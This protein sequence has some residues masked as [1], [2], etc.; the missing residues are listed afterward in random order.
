MYGIDTI[1]L[2]TNETFILRE[3]NALHLGK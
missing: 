2:L 3:G 1:K